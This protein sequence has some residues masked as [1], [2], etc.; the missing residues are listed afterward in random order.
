MTKI[1]QISYNER[2]IIVGDTINDF[3][4]SNIYESYEQDGHVCY[5]VCLKDKSGKEKLWKH[6]LSDN[7]ELEYSLLDQ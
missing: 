6:I 3:T 4:V 1:I 2:L 5:N 7:V